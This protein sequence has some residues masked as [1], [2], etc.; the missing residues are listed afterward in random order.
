MLIPAYGTI[1]KTNK[2]KQALKKPAQEE[3]M[4][5]IGWINPE[6][7][8]FDCM[9][10]MERFQIRYILGNPDTAGK[11]ALAIALKANPKAAWLRSFCITF[12]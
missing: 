12:R 2:E 10:R 3:P 5:I 4:G 11:K 8:S 1:P 9:L 6:D 7:Y